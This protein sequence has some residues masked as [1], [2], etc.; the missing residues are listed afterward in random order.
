MGGVF[1]G[2]ATRAVAAG[3]AAGSVGAKGRFGAFGP[4]VGRAMAALAAPA[5]VPAM[6]DRAAADRQLVVGAVTVIL[7]ARLVDGPIAW[8]VAGL[9]ALGVLVGAGFSR[10]TASA[11]GDDGGSDPAFRGRWESVVSGSA[12]IESGVVPAALAFSLALAFRLVPFDWRLAVALAI[13]YVLLDRTIALE[14]TLALSPDHSAERWKAVLAVLATSFIGFAGIASM[15]DGGMA[16][17]GAPTLGEVDL[18]LLAAADAALA[19]LLGFRLARL[20]PAARREAF[21]SGLGFGAVVA[22]G[23]GLL[24]AMAIPQ[25]LAPALLTLLVYLWD[26]LNATTPSI[27]SDPR[28]RWQVGLLLVLSAVVVGWNLRLRV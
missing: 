19:T 2:G 16:G 21:V 6:L 12:G 25:L 7:L 20:G 11:A 24:R 18:L 22:I 23:A 1:G 9:L 26:A 8:L 5:A 13:A 15:I 3:A 14:R 28:W 10:V 4:G 17:V 27:R